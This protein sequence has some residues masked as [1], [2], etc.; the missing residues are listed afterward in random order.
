MKEAEQD[1]KIKN[2]NNKIGLLLSIYYHS[3]IY[4]QKIEKYVLKLWLKFNKLIDSFKVFYTRKICNFI[5]DG[6]VNSY[7][8][9]LALTKY[10]LYIESNNFKLIV[11]KKKMLN[12]FPKYYL[13]L[14]ID[15][16]IETKQNTSNIIFIHKDDIPIMKGISFIFLINQKLLMKMNI[17]NLI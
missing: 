2:Q 13:N 3:D 15:F 17:I 5:L 10:D 9:S 11:F 12:I 1:K 8:K 7:G 6:I 16:L 14:I 4:S